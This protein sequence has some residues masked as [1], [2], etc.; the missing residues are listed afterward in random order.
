MKRPINFWTQ[1]TKGKQ[2]LA[3]L[4]QTSTMMTNN[5]P[6]PFRPR[7]YWQKITLPFSILSSWSIFLLNDQTVQTLWGWSLTVGSVLMCK[8]WPN[9]K[10][11]VSKFD[12]QCTL[13]MVNCH[14]IAKIL[15]LLVHWSRGHHKHMLW[16]STNGLLV[17]R[18]AFNKAPITPHGHIILQ[19]GWINM[20]CLA[21]G[22]AAHNST[23]WKVRSH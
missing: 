2:I 6:M 5:T 20:T 19:H 3:I 1:I 22:E 14:Q 12:H 8:W 17:M 4:P 13:R 23:N 15:C 21:Q 11:P 9:G 18:N 7:M 10:R 16:S